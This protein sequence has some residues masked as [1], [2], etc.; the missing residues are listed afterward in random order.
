[1][2]DVRPAEL[3]TGE[4]GFWKRKGHI[5]GA[6]N[7]FWGEDLKDDGSWKSKEELTGAYEKLGATPD[8]TIIVSCGQGLMSAHAYFTLKYILGYPKVKNYDGGF[9]QWSNI[10][11]LPVEVGPGQDR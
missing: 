6:I 2:L 5:K 4:K 7:H 9:N 1:L 10:D 8:T 11:E 3:Y